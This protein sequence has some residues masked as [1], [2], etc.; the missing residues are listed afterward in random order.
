MAACAQDDWSYGYWINLC[1]IIC[2]RIT[3]MSYVV[4]FYQIRIFLAGFHI[5][6][7]CS[8]LI[9]KVHPSTKMSQKVK[10]V[11]LLVKIKEFSGGSHSS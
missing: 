1:S 2:K 9:F 6:I 10:V 8:G 4:G 7:L 11:K 3:K 5:V